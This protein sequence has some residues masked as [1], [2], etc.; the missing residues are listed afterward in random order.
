MI[1]Q[2]RIFFKTHDTMIKS[3]AKQLP[4]LGL[5]ASFI[6]SFSASAQ[7]VSTEQG[8]EDVNILPGW[9]IVNQS[10]PL[11]ETSWFQGN[12]RLMEAQSG[13]VTSFIAANYR[14]TTAVD[15]DTSKTICDYLIMPN[16]GNLEAISFYTRTRKAANNFSIFPDRLYV[17]YSPT[18]DITT[19]NCTDDF[20]AFT[21]TLEV[22]NPDLTKDNYP[23]GY[24]FS[25]QKYDI[26]INGN[27]RIAFV[28]Y[29]EDAGYYGTNSMYVGIDTVS[30]TF[31]SASSGTK[32]HA[33]KKMLTSK[34]IGDTQ[35]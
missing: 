28:Y 17:V 34:E 6:A 16:L 25:W 3:T 11:G 2:S 15:D 20:G 9:S 4:R 31:P 21:E 10:N 30:W 29:V 12:R 1:I 18:G 27:G 5:I 13:F 26:D 33:D 8:F 23:D 7:T 14:N 24:P 19:G 35:H 22:I 32:K